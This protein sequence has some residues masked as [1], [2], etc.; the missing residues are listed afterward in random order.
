MCICMHMYVY[1]CKCMCI[2]MHMYVYVCACMCM[3]S[4]YV[5][6]CVRVCV[7][8]CVCVCVCVCACVA[9]ERERGN[10]IGNQGCQDLPP[11]QPCQ[12][13]Q[14]RDTRLHSVQALAGRWDEANSRG[15]I[16]TRECSATD[17]ITLINR[18]KLT[19]LAPTEKKP[20]APRQNAGGHL[21]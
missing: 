8:V 2:C 19:P 9:R 16:R 21:Q 18:L 4:M 11:A 7:R 5:R 10:E 12:A 6:T 20:H 13:V 15:H 17:I 3:Y 1:V 14:Y